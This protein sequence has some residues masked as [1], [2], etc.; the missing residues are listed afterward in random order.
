M[1]IGLFCKEF[2]DLRTSISV[3][4]SNDEVASSNIN[5]GLSLKSDLAIDNLCACPSEIPIPFSPIIAL[6]PF[7]NLSTKS[8]A[9]AFFKASLISLSVAL[10]LPYLKLSFIVPENN[11][12][13]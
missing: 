12:F 1:Q 13:P 4:G 2:I 8:K 3:S 6:I 10:G 5:I 9:Q 11:V 7:S